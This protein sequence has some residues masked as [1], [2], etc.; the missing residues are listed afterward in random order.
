MH[1]LAS[2]SAT[3]AALTGDRFGP[4]ESDWGIIA[5]V[6]F[7]NASVTWALWLAGHLPIR[8]VFPSFSRSA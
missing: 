8:S 2:G 6:I 3:G 1:V 7:R 5:R 4:E